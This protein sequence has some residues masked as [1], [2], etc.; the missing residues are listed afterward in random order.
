MALETVRLSEM[1]RDQLQRVKRATGIGNWNILCRWSLCLSL[2]EEAEPTPVPHGVDSGVEM[3]WKVFG[4]SYSD[5]YRALIMAKLSNS[6]QEG[7]EDNF[8]D[9]FR[10]HLHR[11]IGIL[12][13]LIA[14]NSVDDMG[15]LAIGDY[16]PK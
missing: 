10:R 4:G 3:T 6:G 16:S 12:N 2:A 15:M 13:A 1:Q 9:Y 7:N 14:G 11:G 8:A 5:V